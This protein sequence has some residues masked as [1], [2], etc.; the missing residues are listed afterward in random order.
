MKLIREFI[1]E[2]EIEFLAEANESGGKDYYIKGIFLQADKKNRNG[3]LYPK[4]IMEKQIN[5]Y[6][7]NFVERNRA[8]GELGHPATPTINPDRVSHKIVELREDNNNYEGK[9]KIMNTPM[10]QIVKSFIDDDVLLAVSSRGVGSIKT[11][12]KGISEVQDDFRL[13]T[14]DI[15]HDPSAPDA[16]VEGVMENYD[17]YYDNGILVAQQIEEIRKNIKVTPKS[18]LQEKKVELFER[19]ISSMIDNE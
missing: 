10:G 19:I 4:S 16:F 5:E 17:W 14:V 6:N 3:R 9:A 12:S 18:Q 1:P 7:K 11:N 15:V 8:V 13:S 2:D